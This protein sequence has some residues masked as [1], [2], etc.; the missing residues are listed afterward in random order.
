MAKLLSVR[1]LPNADAPIGT[2]GLTKT[3]MAAA[4]SFSGSRSAFGDGACCCDT[5]P[6]MGATVDGVLVEDSLVVLLE[7]LE[8][9][10]VVVV[11]VFASLGTLSGR[12]TWRVTL[13]TSDISPPSVT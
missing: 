13:T 3:E 2:V 11:F 6:V 4:C 5:S 12:M 10:V 8:L 9:V 7:L 1:S